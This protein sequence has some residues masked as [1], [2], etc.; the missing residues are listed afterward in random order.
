MIRKWMSLPDVEPYWLQCKMKLF[1]SNSAMSPWV[2][3]WDEE[4]KDTWMREKEPYAITENFSNE[5]RFH[6]VM[7][8]FTDWR[9]RTTGRKSCCITG[10]RAEE[11]LNRFKGTTSGLTYK[12]V[13]W[14]RKNKETYC[15]HPFYDWSYRDVWKY[16]M[17]TIWNTILVM[18]KCINWVYQFLIC[19]FQI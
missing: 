10:L 18:T 9:Q 3:I 4:R 6:K 15:F 19:V 13:T 14:G 7:A 8:E 16:I 2:W 17:I 1:N 11:S 5:I 12:N